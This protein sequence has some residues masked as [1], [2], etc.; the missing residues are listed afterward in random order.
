MK[1]VGVFYRP[2]TGSSVP[3]FSS[4]AYIET[5]RSCPVFELSGGVDFDAATEACAEFLRTGE[6]PGDGQQ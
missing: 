2:E 6:M 3:D 1:S 5:L 4:S